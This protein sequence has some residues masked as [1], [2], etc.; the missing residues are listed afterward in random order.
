MKQKRSPW[1]SYE[2]FGFSSQ[3][4]VVVALLAWN[5]TAS[6]T[7]VLASVWNSCLGPEGKESNRPISQ[8]HLQNERT[9]GKAGLEP[10]RAGSCFPQ[11]SKPIPPQLSK[12]WMY[13]TTTQD[14]YSKFRWTQCRW[15]VGYKQTQKD[16][17]VKLTVERNESQCKK[18][19]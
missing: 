14:N 19:Q 13:T 1:N 10:P 7:V 12:Q 15:Q 4:R 18:S 8:R 5:T 6:K 2:T 11:P 3:A 9:D 17:A 16:T